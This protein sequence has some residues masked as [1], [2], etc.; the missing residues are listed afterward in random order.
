MVNSALRVHLGLFGMPLF[1][2]LSRPTGRAIAQ[3]LRWLSWP[4]WR[5]SLAA[6]SERGVMMANRTWS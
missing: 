1:L 4:A 5:Y 3:S 2:S 6:T